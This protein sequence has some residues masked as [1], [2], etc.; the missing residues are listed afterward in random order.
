M[1][2]TRTSL[3]R[4]FLNKVNRFTHVDNVDT[5]NQSKASEGALNAALKT[6]Q[7]TLIVGRTG[8]GKTTTI[9]A[10]ICKGRSF[11]VENTPEISVTPYHLVI[12]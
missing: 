11:T 3:G 1:T 2:E 6:N 12:E 4:M 8:C 10:A 5:V 9:G 7:N